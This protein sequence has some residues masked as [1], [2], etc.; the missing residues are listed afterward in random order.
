MWDLPGP[1]IE[2]VSP[3]FSDGF[4]TTEPPRKPMAFISE[5]KMYLCVGLCF[6]EGSVC[7]L[8]ILF[9]LMFVYLFGCAA[10]SLQHPGS[11][12]AACEI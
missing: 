7:V 3:A 2:S 8:F 10:S 6:S 1:G 11:L 5:R 4:F 9:F 12:V